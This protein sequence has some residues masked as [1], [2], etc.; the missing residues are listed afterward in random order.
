MYRQHGVVVVGNAVL[1]V[2]L[3]VN[4]ALV[5]SLKNERSCEQD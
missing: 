2:P 5:E 3:H 4:L 1:Q